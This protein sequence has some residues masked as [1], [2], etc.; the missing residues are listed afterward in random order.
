MVFL[1]TLGTIAIGFGGFLVLTN[2]ENRKTYKRIRNIQ[3]QPIASAP[4]DGLAMIR[5]IVR[6]SE[7]GI[8]CMPFPAR[9][10][11]WYVLTVFERRGK[12]YWPLVYR[13]SYGFPF[14]LDDGSGQ[15][16]LVYRARAKGVMPERLEGYSN[17]F[18]PPTREFEQFL[19]SRR[20]MTKGVLGLNRGYR[21]KVQY[22]EPG[23]AIYVLGPSS[24]TG[25]RNGGAFYPD[26]SSQ[27]VM[28]LFDQNRDPLYLGKGGEKEFRQIAKSFHSGI[29][30]IALG[31]VFVVMELTVWVVYFLLRIYG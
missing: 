22:V 16:A 27:L 7:N 15:C 17:H 12:N 10:V 18:S 23:E 4:G 9:Y 20:L 3:T 26:T 13:E 19:A 6:P 14:F 30:L 29:V 21:C 5:G 8:V 1:G 11:V 28:S 24:R 25:Q 2:L 31:G